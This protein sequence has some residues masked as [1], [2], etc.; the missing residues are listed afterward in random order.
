MEVF[1]NVPEVVVSVV[2]I[3]INSFDDFANF[4]EC[5]W[6]GLVFWAIEFKRRVDVFVFAVICFNGSIRCFNGSIVDVH[7]WLFID[8]CTFH[9]IVTFLY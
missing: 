5:Q 7:I 8:I 2:V 9:T 1:R 6:L 4:G 3:A